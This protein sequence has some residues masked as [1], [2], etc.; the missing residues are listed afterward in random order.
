MKKFLA[1]SLLFAVTADDAAVEALAESVFCQLPR[2]G[3]ANYA[4][5]ASH[6]SD[7]CVGQRQCRITGEQADLLR[8]LRSMPQVVGVKPRDKIST[9]LRKTEVQSGRHPPVG[10]AEDAH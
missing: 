4:A 7:E 2:L 5:A 8:K 6:V 3:I 1:A 10:L 9:N